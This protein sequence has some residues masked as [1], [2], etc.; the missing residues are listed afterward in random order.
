MYWR[1]AAHWFVC[2]FFC[3]CVSVRL[4]FDV[5]VLPLRARVLWG[6]SFWACAFLC[7]RAA[8]CLSKHGSL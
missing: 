3:I 1:F 2:L 7:V 8:E 4:F 6:L 5:P